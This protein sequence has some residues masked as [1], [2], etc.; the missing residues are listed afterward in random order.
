MLQN[1]QSVY[2]QNAKVIKDKGIL[3]TTPEKGRIKKW[4]LN[5]AFNPGPDKNDIL[6]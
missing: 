3:E 2:F 6:L 1:N 4:Q 5:A